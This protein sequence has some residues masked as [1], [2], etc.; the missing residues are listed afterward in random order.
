MGQTKIVQHF[1]NQQYYL[2]IG[3]GKHTENME[4]LVCYRALYPPFDYYMR[5]KEM[6]FGKVDA[7]KYPNHVGKD[8]FSYVENLPPH[9]IQ[10]LNQWYG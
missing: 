7:S 5:P 8:R 6:F 4:E 10:L 2:I 3:I 9:V 1:N